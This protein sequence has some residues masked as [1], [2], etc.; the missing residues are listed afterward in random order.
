VLDGEPL[1]LRRTAATSALASTYLS[2]AD[3]KTLLLVGT[4]R[5]A[6]HMAAAHGTVRDFE[7]VLVWGRSEDKARALVERLSGEG[8]SAQAVR[9]L[10]RA[11]AEA[12]VIT[13]ATTAREPVLHG[14][15]IRSGTHVDLVGAFAPDMRE[16]DDAL[17]ARAELFVDTCGGALE[18]AGDLLQAMESG[19]I[20]RD[21]VRAELAEL[22][23]GRHPGRT[24]SGAITVFKSVGA[25]VADLCAA[26][27]VM[28]RNRRG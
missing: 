3:S 11:A 13:C 9:D 1:T 14:A 27:L 6:P 16:S 21:S 19:A 17:L 25:A 8:I 12:D 10:A 22:V 26:G 23:C 24:S 7:R 15:W 2:R 18:E 4:G 20:S 28:A 5:L